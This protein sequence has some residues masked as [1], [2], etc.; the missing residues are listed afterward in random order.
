MKLGIDIDDVVVDTS[1]YAYRYLFPLFRNNPEI[2]NN[3]KDIMKGKL[4][5]DKMKQAADKYAPKIWKKAKVKPDA[6]K[7]LNSL[8][9]QGYTLIYITA[10]NKSINSEAEA[11]TYEYFKKH[12]IPYDKIVFGKI[13]EGLQ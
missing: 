10:R 3:L 13:L 4:T 6:V 7:V 9:E 12:N 1:K 5:S 2:M 11:I 8:K